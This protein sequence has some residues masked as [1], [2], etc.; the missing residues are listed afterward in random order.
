M[1]SH[2]HMKRWALALRKRL[3]V[4]RKWPIEHNDPNWWVAD[5]LAIN[6]HDRGVELESTEKQLQLN[7]RPTDFKIGALNT[8][9]LRK[10]VIHCL[11]VFSVIDYCFNS[12]CQNEGTCHSISDNYTCDCPGQYTGHSCGG[13]SHK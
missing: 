5:Q 7:P 10:I 1:K 9:W 8:L 4:I 12:P 3:K 2:F 11:A 13:Q 6:K